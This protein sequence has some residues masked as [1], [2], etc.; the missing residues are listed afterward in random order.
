MPDECRQHADQ[1]ER[2]EQVGADC[3]QIELWIAQAQGLERLDLQGRDHLPVANDRLPAL[4]GLLDRRD[5]LA[6]VLLSA[7]RGFDVEDQVG[8]DEALHQLGDHRPICFGEQRTYPQWDVLAYFLHALLGDPI[9]QHVLEHALALVRE[10]RPAKL[11]D[12]GQPP[13][14]GFRQRWRGKRRNRR[15]ALVDRAFRLVV[16]N[17]VDGLQQVGQAAGLLDD[18]VAVEL[19]HGRHLGSGRVARGAR[20]ELTDERDAARRFDGHGRD[21]AVAHFVDARQQVDAQDGRQEQGGDDADQ[22]PQRNSRT[23]STPR[24]AGR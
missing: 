20:A 14:R 3:A 7:R 19:D 17:G 9:P 6:R 4:E 23:S 24:G 18:A 5:R 12:L 16:S 8:A 13:R 22:Q 11:V 10:G 21:V 1:R 2:Q 15:G